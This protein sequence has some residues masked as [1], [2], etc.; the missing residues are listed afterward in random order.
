MSYH[1]YISGWVGRTGNHILQ[2]SQAIYLSEKCNGVCEYRENDFFENKIFD[3]SNGSSIQNYFN[4]TFWEL[5]PKYT[6]TNEN[7][8][9]DLHYQRP[10]ILR[11]YILPIFKPYQKIDL[12][13]DLVIHIRGGDSIE[14]KGCPPQYVQAPL[15]YFLRILEKENPQKVLLVC[16]DNKNPVI[17]KLK[18]TKYNIEV[19]VGNNVFTDAN[20][21]LNAKKIVIGGVTTFSLLLSQMSSNVEVVYYPK[22]E[23][24]WILKEDELW[25]RDHWY[26]FENF[27]GKMEADVIP[28]SLNNYIKIGQWG[29]Y[30]LDE[31]KN[32]MLTHSTNDVFLK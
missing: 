29:Y 1:Y 6:P 22:F 10:R 15:S 24:G 28:V 21:I 16:E 3:F 14:G 18:E 2:L 11:E 26:N 32:Y 7:Y 8:S 23:D 27:L 13:Y 4:E 17:E 31:K 30:S 25:K 19:H 9:A 20:K 5:N 12:N